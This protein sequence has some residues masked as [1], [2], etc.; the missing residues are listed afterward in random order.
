V[1]ILLVEQNMRV[2]LKLAGRIYVMSKG[3][4]F[5]QG[6]AQELKESPEIR[7]RYLEV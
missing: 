3:N 1:A 4:I 5:F 2:A 7:Q 6:T